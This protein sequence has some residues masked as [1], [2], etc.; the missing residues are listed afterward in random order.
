[1]SLQQEVRLL[2]P[3]GLLPQIV[4]YDKEQARLLVDL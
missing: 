1:M 2:L 4:L 3:I